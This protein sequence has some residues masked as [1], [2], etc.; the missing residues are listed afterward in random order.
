MHCYARSSIAHT[1]VGLKEG[2]VYSIKNFIVQPNKDEYRIISQ[3]PFILEFDGSTIIRKVVVNPKPFIR[4]PFELADFDETELTDNKYLIGNAVCLHNFY[5]PVFLYH[6][7]FKLF[8]YVI[9]C[10]Q[11]S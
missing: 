8:L 7:I 5:C 3:D 2:G 11:M 4:Y 1:F 6:V 9:G 10:H